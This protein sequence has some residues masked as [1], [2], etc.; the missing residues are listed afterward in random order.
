M[1]STRACSGSPIFSQRRGGRRRWRSPAAQGR[2]RW[3]RQREERVAG[4]VWE[5]ALGEAFFLLYTPFWLNL[6]IDI[7]VPFKLDEVLLLID[8]GPHS[9]LYSRAMCRGRVDHCS[10]RCRATGAGPCKQTP[11]MMTT[12]WEL[13]LRLEA[14]TGLSG[15]LQRSTH[16]GLEHGEREQRLATEEDAMA[17]Q[18]A[19][20]QL[21]G[22]RHRQIQKD[23]IF[24]G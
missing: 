8:Q 23:D 1:L 11:L 20:G 19:L 2:W 17:V 5:Q 14:S 7:I 24:W 21:D 16:L 4:R 18:H 6:C 22:R 13:S 15:T 3:Q 12:N 9:Q 10:R